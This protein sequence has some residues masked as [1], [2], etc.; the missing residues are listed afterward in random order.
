MKKTAAIAALLILLPAAAL[1]QDKTYLYSAKADFS[2]ETGYRKTSGVSG[3]LFG[4]LSVADENQVVKN[5]QLAAIKSLKKAGISPDRAQLL[6]VGLSGTRTRVLSTGTADSVGLLG[7]KKTHSYANFGLSGKLHVGF[8]SSVK[9]DIPGYTRQ[10]VAS[11]TVRVR[12][13]ASGVN[14]RTLGEVKAPVSGLR[15]G[16]YTAANAEQ[17]V[18]GLRLSKVIPGKVK[19]RLGDKVKRTLGKKAP[20]P[21]YLSTSVM[22]QL[23]DGSTKK[24]NLGRPKH[25]V[26]RKAMLRQVKARGVGR[27]LSPNYY[28]VK[29]ARLMA[30]RR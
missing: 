13:G 27:F 9:A 1:A 18:G 21:G 19:H 14:A 23:K 17:D 10:E 11:A 4:H 29:A 3:A 30:R 22:L 7:T 24:V 12:G 20:V 15:L 2:L 26:E 8:L 6:P 25:E 5:G 28:K 16:A